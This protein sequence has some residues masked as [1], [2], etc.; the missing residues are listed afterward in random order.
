VRKLA[1]LLLVTGLSLVSA[2]PAMATRS[3]QTQTV[4][5]PPAFEA[6]YWLAAQVTPGG[7]LESPWAPGTADVSTTEQAVLALAAVGVGAEQLTAMEDYLEAN[8]TD[9][10]QSAGVDSPQRIGLLILGAIATGR[11]PTN[12]GGVDLVA[13]LNATLQPSGLYGS[14][15]AT[16]DGAYRQ[17]IALLALAA[18][19]STPP[20]AATNWLK[21]QQCA[22]GGWQAIRTDTSVPCGPVDPASFSGPDTNATALA[23]L[24]LHSVGV[25][26]PVDPTAWF[27][28]VRAADGGWSL[29]STPAGTSDANSTGL[30]LQA[31]VAL[32]GE[33][34]QPGVRALLALQVSCA[35][36]AADRGGF[37]FQPDPT[38]QSLT[39]DVMA[40]TQALWGLA[41]VAFPIP[42]GS[43]LPAQPPCYVAQQPTTTTTIPA[44]TVAPTVTTVPSGVGANHANPYASQD[45][46]PPLPLTGATVA[47]MDAGSV[48]AIGAL[49]LLAGLVLRAARRRRAAA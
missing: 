23:A 8:V 11:T 25:T 1:S 18:V 44:T 22:D 32:H 5:N 30:V 6:A 39:A 42:E 17:G 19:E 38:D 27:D 31:L 9:A 16:Y 20:V 28:A 21:N 34:D 10:M 12:F 13:R 47:G 24:G 26:P 40:T 4:E 3:A 48:A 2:S 33:L 29:Y 45:G 43:P 46:P 15:D 35:S 36:G 49:T 37:A 41:G 7:Y 14:A